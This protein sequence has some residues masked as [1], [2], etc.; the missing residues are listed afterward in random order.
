MDILGLGLA[1]Q[2]HGG[3]GQEVQVRCTCEVVMQK[4]QGA[5]EFVLQQWQWPQGLQLQWPLSRCRYNMGVLWP[6]V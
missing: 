1:G 2:M 3:W 5:E 6:V 4:S